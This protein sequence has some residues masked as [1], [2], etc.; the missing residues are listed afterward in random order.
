MGTLAKRPGTR[1]QTMITRIVAA[2]AALTLSGTAGLAGNLV[3]QPVNPAFGGSPLNGSWLQADAQAQNIPQAADQRRQQV[4]NAVN[5][6][7]TSRTLTPGQIFAQQ[8]QSQLFSSLA[9]QITQSIFG[10]NAR[11]NGTFTFQGTT[12]D[13]VRIG[14]DV[15]VTINDGQTITQVVVPAAP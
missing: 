11:P 7:A 9:N 2:I 4:F 6:A 15:R 5:Q 3:Y 14:S 1:V 13:F 8:L 12:I 10:E